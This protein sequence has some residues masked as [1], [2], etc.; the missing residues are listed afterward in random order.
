MYRTVYLIIR[1]VLQGAGTLEKFGNFFHFSITD[2]GFGTAGG[3]KHLTAED[4][5]EMGFSR[6]GQ[7]VLNNN[8]IAGPPANTAM[9]CNSA[10]M[11]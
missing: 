8:L 6:G 11:W 4:V 3:F 10:G 5:R 2:E 1:R 7:R 9:D